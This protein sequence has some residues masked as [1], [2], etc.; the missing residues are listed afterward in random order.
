MWTDAEMDYLKN[1][2]GRVKEQELVDG[3]QEL[4]GR[5]TT[6]TTVRNKAKKQGIKNTFRTEY[7]V[8]KGDAY[9]FTDDLKGCLDK[10][11]VA[12]Y[13]FRSQI[14]RSGE[15]EDGIHVVDLGRWKPD[16]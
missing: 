13:T 6:K 3:L 14:T 9:Q 15:Y 7:A 2:F 12:E 5:K 1:N 4:F 8:Y 16:E 11:G 10:L